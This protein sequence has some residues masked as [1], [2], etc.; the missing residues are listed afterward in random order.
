M[1]K[2]HNFSFSQKQYFVSLTKIMLKN[3]L[4]RNKT[5]KNSFSNSEVWIKATRREVVVRNITYQLWYQSWY[6]LR[7]QL[8]HSLWIFCVSIH[9]A[10]SVNNLWIFVKFA[11]W[12]IILYENAFIFSINK[13]KRK[14]FTKKSEKIKLNI[15][16]HVLHVWD[17]LYSMSNLTNLPLR[18]TLPLGI[19][20]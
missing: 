5:T 8:E 4:G 20:I 16:H 7:S 18:P 9:Y 1:I 11:E 3:I 2:A 13:P 10:Q 12:K 14:L 19:M 15:K 6:W 17:T